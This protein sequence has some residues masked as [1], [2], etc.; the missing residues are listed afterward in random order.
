MDNSQREK[1]MNKAN[2]D[3]LIRDLFKVA[4]IFIALKGIKIV[5]D[6]LN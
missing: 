6:K 2:Q 4:T 1:E 3:K 5:T